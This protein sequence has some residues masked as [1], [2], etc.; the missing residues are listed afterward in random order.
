MLKKIV[1]ATLMLGV[2]SALAQE[3]PKTESVAAVPEDNQRDW[4][5]TLDPYASYEFQADIH[6]SDASVKI[7]RTGALGD[8]RLKLTPDWSVNLGIGAE[9]SNYNF[10]NTIGMLPVDR[11]KLDLYSVTVAP[12]VTYKISDTWSVTGGAM[13]SFSGEDS[14][15]FSQTGTYGVF[16]AATY[17][18]SD[19]L[20]LTFGLAGMSQLEDDFM[21]APTFG[22]RWQINDTLSLTTGGAGRGY[23][24]RLTQDLNK[25]WAVSLLASYEGR[26]YRLNDSGPLADAVMRD[27]TLPVG[28][29][30]A[31]KPTPS[32]VIKGTAGVELYQRIE[33]DDRNGNDISDRVA[34]PAPF[35]MLSAVFKF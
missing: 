5:I 29:E 31:W 9:Y 1:L 30:L 11:L 2:T 17:K 6:R 20:S 27:T 24:V 15:D 34:D 25:Q 8:I 12:G 14:A 26:A 13:A 19:R 10:S 16:A 35:V 3:E 28:V 7:A 23:T 22:V 4:S 33:F 21:V 18:V 32:I